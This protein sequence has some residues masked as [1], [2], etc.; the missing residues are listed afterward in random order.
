V[1]PQDPLINALELCAPKGGIFGRIKEFNIGKRSTIYEHST[2]TT[3]DFYGGSNTEEPT[4]IQQ[5]S[6]QDKSYPTVNSFLK[7]LRLNFELKTNQTLT[8]GARLFIL[9][10]KSALSQGNFRPKIVDFKTLKFPEK[11]NETCLA[12]KIKLFNNQISTPQLKS[13]AENCSSVQTNSDKR[14][15]IRNFAQQGC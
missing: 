8:I 9:D 14:Q 6:S 5:V 10:A 11:I 7:K 15:V 4:T 2:T 13:L 12:S 3:H 1:S